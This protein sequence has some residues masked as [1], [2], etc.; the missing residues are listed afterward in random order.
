[1][2]AIWRSF[3]PQ[4]EISTTTSQPRK[5]RTRARTLP[6]Y[7]A[8]QMHWI[9]S[10]PDEEKRQC[11]RRGLRCKMTLIDTSSGE[12]TEAHPVPADCLNV[13]DGGLYG[14]VPI[15]YGV[16]MGQRYTFQLA[17]PERGPEPGTEQMI[18]QQGIIVR[19]E[20]LINPNGEGDRVGIG[21][22]LIGRRSGVIP[23]PDHP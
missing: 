23:M 8:Y 2:S 4:A 9:R 16:A 13:S 15:G 20:L 12:D 17:I 7:K 1:M 19:A 5:G 11:N 22:Q 6:T 21:V 14:V 3:H 18:T 10:S